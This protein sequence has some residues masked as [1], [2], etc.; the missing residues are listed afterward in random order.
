MPK[1]AEG[2]GGPKTRKRGISVSPCF[3]FFFFL[4]LLQGKS[5][6]TP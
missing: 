2:Y 4:L 3:A 5:Y 1:V 6:L